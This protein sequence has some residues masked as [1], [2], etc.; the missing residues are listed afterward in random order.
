MGH[1]LDQAFQDSNHA[2]YGLAQGRN[3]RMRRHGRRGGR[4]LRRR[5]RRRLPVQG[6]SCPRSTCPRGKRPRSSCPRNSMSRRSR[7][8]CSKWRPGPRLWRLC[9][10]RPFGQCFANPCPW[11]RGLRNRKL[12]AWTAA[13]RRRWRHWRARTWHSLWARHPSP[14]LALRGMDGR[15][16]LHEVVDRLGQRIRS[17]GRIDHSG[18]RPLRRRLYRPRQSRAANAPRRIRHHWRH[19][20]RPTA[21][22]VSGRCSLGRHRGLR[23]RRHDFRS[24]HGLG[25]MCKTVTHIG[26][27]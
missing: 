25:C 24:L 3:V 16:F 18:R 21:R 9:W 4:F 17:R 6:K 8:R 7:R 1:R 26:H 5:Q 14:G 22:A 11:P 19:A 15:R 12:R 2:P 13:R 10:H 20:R 27:A 23:R